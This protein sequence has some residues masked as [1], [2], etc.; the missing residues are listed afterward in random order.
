MYKTSFIC[1][2]Q[3]TYSRIMRFTCYAHYI[4][5]ALYDCI[6]AHEFAASF[7]SFKTGASVIYGCKETNI[8]PKNNGFQIKWQFVALRCRPWHSKVFI[9]NTLLP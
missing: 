9:S 4:S 5:C 7:A 1:V 8:F 3:Q 6:D 2:M